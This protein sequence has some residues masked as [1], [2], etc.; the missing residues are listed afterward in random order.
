VSACQSG[1][2]EQFHDVFARMLDFVRSHGQAVAE[3][4]LAGSDVILPPPDTSIDEAKAEFT[5]DGLIP[6]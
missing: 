6:G 2:E 5:G 3:D 4:T 1:D